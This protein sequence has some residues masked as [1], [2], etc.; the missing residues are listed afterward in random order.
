MKIRLMLTMVLVTA[1]GCSVLQAEQVVIG[2]G[3]RSGVY[4]QAGRVICRLIT[5]NL[6]D[7][8]CR[9]LETPGS[10][11][12][13]N[14]VQVGALELGLVQSDIQYHAVNH[15]GPFQFVDR[16]Y[17]NLRALFSLH[18]EPF[19]LVARRDSG[20]K[21]LDDLK[22][23]RVNIGNPGSGQRAT[24]EVVMQAK[25]WSKDDFQLVTE[26]PASQQSLA[27]C[28]NRIQ[29]M[30]YTVGHPNRSVARA[31]DLCNAEI[32]NVADPVIDALVAANP[33]YNYT[34]IPADT[35]TGM[36]EPVKTFGVLATVVS[37]ADVDDELVY[38]VVKTLFEDFDRFRRM[39]R[40]FQD[41]EPSNMI[42][43]GLS[44][45]LHKGAE[46]YYRE[47]GWLE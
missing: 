11:S 41:L 45:P 43:N 14:N 42:K 26:L 38:R 36:Q 27:L 35:Y 29:A 19:T 30:I 24:M 6:Q 16:P 47:R 5:R 44:A 39:H 15:S 20:I 37:S 40:V 4:F 23:R 46:R 25:G 33:Y 10:L 13:L 8:G 1:L 22:G 32:V 21:A 34:L 28:H 3:S 7:A 2:T 31:V 17:D 12:N 9:V 18:T